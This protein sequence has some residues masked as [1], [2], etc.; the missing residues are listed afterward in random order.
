MNALEQIQ[1]LRDT[2]TIH[3]PENAS[4]NIR[5]VYK[6]RRDGTLEKIVPQPA[7]IEEFVPEQEQIYGSGRVQGKVINYNIKGIS[8]RNY[9]RADLEGFD[10]AVIDRNGD[11][12]DMKFERLEETQWWN[13]T[14][15]Q[16]QGQQTYRY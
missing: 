5:E 6:V 14:L 16:K 13:I 3:L 2:L 4:F 7:F 9:K 12:I 11:R 1:A 15:V 10:F 8:K